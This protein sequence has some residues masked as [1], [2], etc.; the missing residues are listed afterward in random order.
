M[1]LFNGDCLE[2]MKNIPSGSVDLVLTDPPYGTIKNIPLNGY[3]RNNTNTTWDT[4]I[5][6]EQMFFRSTGF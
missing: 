5:D 3:V 6:F 1:L 4:T 2:E